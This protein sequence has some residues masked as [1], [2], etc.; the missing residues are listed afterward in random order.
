MKTTMTERDKKLLTGMLIGVIIV[1]IGYWGIRPQLKQYA[2]LQ[3]KI[4]KEEEEKKINQMKLAN[5]GMIEIQ[6]EEYEQKVLEKKDEFYQIKNSSEIDRMMTELALDTN[7][8]IYDLNFSVP[9]TPTQRMAYQFSSL[10]AWQKEA[11]E[12]LEKADELTTSSS[13][14]GLLDDLKEEDEDTSD[15]SGDSSMDIMD[16]M[17]VEEGGYQPNTEIYAVPVTMSVGGEVAALEKF[18]EK[19]I[20]NDKR[21]LLVS[22]AWG[23]YRDIYGRDVSSGVTYNSSPDQKENLGE[24]S[25]EV[26]KN[27]VTKRSLTVKLE[28]YMCDTASVVENMNLDEDTGA[29]AEE[30]EGTGED[31]SDDLLED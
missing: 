4:E 16:E 14:T 26:E 22:Y 2:A 27:V 15:F 28:I 7:L 8:D 24:D 9:K 13:S 5:V 12:N 11:K 31:A 21:V 6:A 23:N 19:I 10:Y 17:L 30:S 18:I 3:S 29:A 1:A 20:N 25:S